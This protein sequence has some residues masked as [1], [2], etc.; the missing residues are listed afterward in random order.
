MDPSYTFTGACPFLCPPESKYFGVIIGAGGSFDVVASY[1]WKAE[2]FIQSVSKT[3]ISISGGPGYNVGAGVIASGEDS[4]D[5]ISIQGGWGG[6]IELG[7]SSG[8]NT[9]VISSISVSYE[10][11][12]TLGVSIWSVDNQELRVNDKGQAYFSG[13]VNGVI[14][15]KCNAIENNGK[16]EPSCIWSSDNYWKE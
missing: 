11:A 5:G 10:E 3:N 7:F 9:N 2:Y 16:Y 12:N 15:V 14:D 4:F 1:D 13:K 6:G 8:G